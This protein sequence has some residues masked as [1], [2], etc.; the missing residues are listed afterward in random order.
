VCTCFITC[1]TPKSL[2]PP[3]GSFYCNEDPYD[4]RKC[5]YC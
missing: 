4:N 5:V 2:T 3:S 1:E